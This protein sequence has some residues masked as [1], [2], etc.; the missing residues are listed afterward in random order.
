MATNLAELE[1]LLSTPSAIEPNRE[2]ILRTLSSMLNS[3]Q[4]DPPRA[5]HELVLRAL[6]HR[7]AFGSLAPVLDSLARDRGLYPYVDP[8]GLG[9]RELLAYE[10]H[11]LSE[12]GDVVLHHAQTVVYDLL[13]RGESV[14]LSAPTSFGKSLLID[15]VIAA[16]RFSNVLVVVP[17]IALIDETRRRLAKRFAGEYKV[18]THVGQALAER[19]IFVLTQE[20]VLDH[21]ALPEIEFFVIDE[22][23]KLDMR[24][25]SDRALLLNQAFYRLQRTGAQFY[26]LGPNIRQLSVDLP[27]RLNCRFIVTDYTTVVSEIRRVRA[28]P[29]DRLGELVRLARSLKEPTLIY[30]ASPAS[31]RRV[32]TALA[33]AI[34]RRNESMEHAADWI[35][36]E[37][38][39]DWA[40]GR[41]LRSGVGIHHGRVPR[42][43]AQFC[44]RAFNSGDLRYLIC[45]ST[46]IEGVNTKAKNV[47]VY[48]NRIATQKFDFFTFNNIRGRSG[49]M[50][51]HFVG[52]VYLFNDPPEEELPLVDVP[53]FTQSDT[54]PESLLVQLDD[55]DLTERSRARLSELAEQQ[56]LEMDVIR[57]NS[58]VDPHGQI[59]LARHLWSLAEAAATTV[60][61]S[62][63][64]KWEELL[65]SCELI[66]D[67]LLP[68]GGLR[69]QASSA[70]QL[71]F[72]VQQYRKARSVRKLVL[73]ELAQQGDS[74]DA[75]EAV[76]RVLDF[77]RYWGTFNFPRYLMALDRIQRFVFE[78]RELP[79]GNYVAF[80]G[81]LENQF[82]PPGLAALEEYGL[83]TQVAQK[84][85]RR[86][87]ELG[88][89][90]EALDGLRR[91]SPAD[92]EGLTPFEI[93]LALDAQ[94][95]LAPSPPTRRI[96]ERARE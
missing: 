23:Y 17:T 35:A 79:A 75:D 96:S 8:K 89:L 6:A 93:A 5:V 91:L 34:T 3:Y 59:K 19:N 87:G 86:L 12:L 9:E 18:V 80:A 4:T 45:T 48:D 67:Y 26:L 73:Q 30:C 70:R 15:A 76:E 38:H 39:A 94:A 14:I 65:L 90:D 56:W 60:A 36:T 74:P 21:P 29:A 64:P 55:A 11:R 58:G 7:K 31:A 10:A 57:A 25:D 95:S 41:A 40:V 84:L 27:E 54:V 44:V 2:W 53:V 24:K 46:L 68:V 22:F 83:P 47:I 32:A 13:I 66:W 52:H 28:K 72:K 63:F 20:R 88:T 78:H 43:L 69:G 82:L 50:F 61:W 81:S 33:A 49:R 62:G 71:A 37:Y 77:V 51:E 42:S 16:R 1:R 92:L 85:G